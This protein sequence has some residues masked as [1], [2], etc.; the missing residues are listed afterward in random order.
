MGCDTAGQSV[1]ESV[2]PI[3]LVQIRPALVEANKVAPGLIEAIDQVDA[4]LQEFEAK[5]DTEIAAIA[6]VRASPLMPR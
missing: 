5:L 3:L 6:A 4:S 2:G 1:H